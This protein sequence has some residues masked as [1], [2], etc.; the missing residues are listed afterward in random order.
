VRSCLARVCTGV[1]MC[2]G[3][4]AMQRRSAKPPAHPRPSTHMRTRTRRCAWPMTFSW[5]LACCSSCSRRPRSLGRGQRPQTAQRQRRRSSLWVMPQQPRPQ[6][7]LLRHQQRRRQQTQQQARQSWLA[8]WGRW[9]RTTT[10]PTTCRTTTWRTRC[11][12]CTRSPWWVLRSWVFARVPSA[13][14]PGRLPATNARAACCHACMCSAAPSPSPPPTHT[15]ADTHTHTHTPTHTHTHTHTHTPT[16]RHTHTHTHTHTH[17]HAQLLRAT[18]AAALL[19]P[20]ERLV[21]LIAAICHDLDHDGRTNSFHISS[22]SPLAQRYNDR[23]GGGGG[24]RVCACVC[25]YVCVRV[26]VCVCRWGPWVCVCVRGWVQG[27]PRGAPAPAR[28]LLLRL[29]SSCPHTQPSCPCRHMHTHIHTHTNTRPCCSPGE[30]PLRAHVRAAV[31]AR[32]QP[33]VLLCQPGGL[34]RGARRAHRVHPGDRHAPSLRADA[35][36]R[37]ACGRPAAERQRRRRQAAAG[38]RA[39]GGGGGRGAGGDLGC[40]C[41]RSWW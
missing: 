33:A 15:H 41:V 10:A 32:R 39:G 2:S 28:Q 24:V 16:H 23:S 25:V 3:L 14:S 36:P 6:R 34:F 13:H 1:C 21:L 29:P 27:T 26:C 17:R 4:P 38:V 37:V 35:G 11:K 9:L 30:P 31:A 18:D 22:R 5:P 40:V 12:C 19:S 20:A 8:S 7:P